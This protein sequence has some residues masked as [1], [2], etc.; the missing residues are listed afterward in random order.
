MLGGRLDYQVK[1]QGYR[2]ELG[3]I[4]YHAREYLEG[5]NAVAVA[6]ENET[7]NTEIALFVEGK[8]E[9][10]DKLIKYLLE[11]IPPYMVP[12][13]T[14]VKDIFPLNTNGKVDRIKLKASIPL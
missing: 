1:I 13:K 2:I 5:N 9:N 10:Q 6:F 3:E 12:T 7:G 14:F 8:L 4:E 11:K